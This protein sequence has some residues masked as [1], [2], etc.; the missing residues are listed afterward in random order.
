MGNW[1]DGG[2]ASTSQ[3]QFSPV[4]IDLGTGRTA[5]A[6]SA[7]YEH[8]CV[9]L[10]NGELKCWG[11]DSSG[12]VGDGGTNDVAVHSPASVDLGTGRTAVAVSAGGWFTCAILDNGDLKCWGNDLNGQLGNGA[13]TSNVL[14]PSST[15]IDLGTGRTA[16]AVSAGREHACVILDN[17]DLKCWGDDAYGQLGD[18]GSNTDIA[19]PSSTA[20]D[21]GTGR[22]AVAVDAGGQYTCAILDNG[23]AK[24]WGR[25]SSGQLGDG[26][27]I[28]TSDYT[29]APSSTAIDLGTGRTAVALSA[30]IFLHTCV[31]LDNGEAKCWGKYDRGRLGYGQ[32]GQGDASS[33]PSATINFGTGRTAVAIVAGSEHTCALLNDGNLSCWGNDNKGQLGDGAGLYDKWTPVLVAGSDTWDSSTGALVINNVTGATCTV[34]PALPTGLNLDSSTCTISGTP[35]VATTNTSYNVTA[36]IGG[37]TYHLSVWLSTSHLALI[38]SAEGADLSVDVPMSNITFQ[39]NAS[40]AGSA[41]FAYA[42][43]KIS[44]EY[45]HS[46]AILDNG[47]LKCWGDSGSGKLGHGGAYDLLAPS[48]TAINLG[49]GRTAV[50]VSAGYGHTC[51]ILDNGDLKCWGSDNNGRLG[52]PGAAQGL[53]TPPSTSINLG[54]GRT[55]VAVATGNYHTCAILDNGDLKCWGA[56]GYGQ[57]GDG[58]T[59][60]DLHTPSTTPIDLGTG[61]TAVAVSAGYFHTCAILDN[62][63][64]KCW[65][66]D[67]KGQ[68]GDG[69]TSHSSSTYT[70]SPSTTPIDLGTGRTAVALS[71][72]S[73]HTCAILDN[74]DLKCWGSDNVGQLG[75]GGTTHNSGTM[76]TQPSS[77][78]VNL[79]TGRTAV[80]VSASNQH[81]CAILDNGDLKCWGSDGYGKLGTPGPAS[82]LM[83]PS[84]TPI[85]LGTTRTAV[86]VSAGFD[87]T[88]AILDN[89]DMK[90]WGRDNQGQLGDGGTKTDQ[91]VPV[92]V[93]GSNTWDS[94]TGLS[95]PMTDI[96]GATCTVSPA[97]PTGLSI[98]SNT[99]TI[100]GT[101]TVATSNTTYTVTA[102]ISGTTFQADVWFSSSYLELTP[103]VEGAD[104]SVD[105][106]MANITFQYNATAASGSPSAPAFA[107][108]NSK[109]SGDHNH[110]CAILDNGDLKCWGMGGTGRWAMVP[111]PTSTRL[112]PQRLTSAQAAQRLHWRLVSTSPA[113]SL[114][115]VT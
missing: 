103:S 28:S 66:M 94:S 92:L 110:N 96:T 19:A 36:L 18:G 10:D 71:T 5:L 85:D 98:D 35:T 9:I 27:T 65:G 15:P 59:D 38:P 23:D 79:G 8:T 4:S 46:C 12:Q 113:P 48:S 81:T 82:G 76:V 61:R 58:G 99:C 105:V 2:T 3:A 20:I 91:P 14:A 80:A 68:L 37:A 1:G 33:P 39:Y 56:D 22:T 95:S 44:S 43:N 108:A 26:G 31:I 114:T 77:T 52:T 41:A 86:A 109:L 32:S 70:T 112:H 88:C 25:D 54:T 45:D 102:V 17:G 47:D 63:D 50:A 97:L 100:S 55:A 49:T 21:L 74:G 90:C 84:S 106:P 69:G 57:L 67:S 104:L 60:T 29:T 89:D 93:S 24:C 87:H 42:N 40:A 73:Y 13:A 16:V 62:G 11:R 111:T 107:Y 75:D 30:S 83:A 53:T 101:P 6:V 51:A 78:P 72:G 115:T 64:M 34:S 7:G